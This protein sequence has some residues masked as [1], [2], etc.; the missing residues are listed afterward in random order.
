MSDAP[1]PADKEPAEG[2]DETVDAELERQDAEG[3]EGAAE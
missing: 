3:D 1:S 2:S